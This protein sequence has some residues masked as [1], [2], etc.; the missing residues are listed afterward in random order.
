[1][2]P[3]PDPPGKPRKGRAPRFAREKPAVRR[4]LL[5][6]AAIRCLGEG[7]MGAFTVDRI[8]REAKVSRGLINHYFKSKDDLL[9][10]AYEAMTDYLAAAPRNSLAEAPASPCGQLI[11]LIEASFDPDIFE[12]SKLKAWLTLWGE[13][14]TNPALQALHRKRY[15]AYR[16]GLA[17]ALSAVAEE[18]GRQLDAQRLAVKLVALI[19]GLWLEWCFAPDLLSSDEARA[20]CYDLVEVSLG[21]IKR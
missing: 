5:I 4:R 17:A 21:P 1:M 3:A 14:T 19:D 13:V 16:G 8:C 7:G 15:H 9:V 6:E 10:A 12:R 20:A 11:G 18:R 2:D